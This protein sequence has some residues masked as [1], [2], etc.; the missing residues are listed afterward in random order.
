MIISTTC[1]VFLPDH[2]VD[3]FILNLISGSNIAKKRG[4]LSSF[5]RMFL[6]TFLFYHSFGVNNII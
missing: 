5:F 1:L 4:G 2:V 6:H 3:F